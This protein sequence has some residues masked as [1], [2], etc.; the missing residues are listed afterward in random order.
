MFNKILITAGIII[1]A[2]GAITKDWKGIV[3][4][5]LVLA[6]ALYLME[7]ERRSR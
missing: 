1:L 2:F 7:T 6:G 4:G 3:T 5:G